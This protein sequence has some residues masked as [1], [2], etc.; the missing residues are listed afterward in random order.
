MFFKL[1]NKIVNRPS[2]CNKFRYKMFPRTEASEKYAPPF[3]ATGWFRWRT[4]RSPQAGID[5]LKWAATL[6]NND[7]LEE[8]HADRGKPT[9]QAL[10]AIEML[11]LYTWWTEVY[12]K[13]PDPHDASGWSAI[14]EKRRLADPDGGVMSLFEDRSEE[15]RNESRVVL[16]ILHK[17]EEQYTQEDEDMMIRLIKIRDSLWT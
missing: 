2:E 16:D 14:Y 4:W 13:R 5:H 1:L 12:P 8:G 10:A 11:E 9:R 17:I 7:W 15:E 6:N 3:W